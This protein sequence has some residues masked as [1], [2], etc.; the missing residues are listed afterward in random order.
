MTDL[1]IDTPEKERAVRDWIQANTDY[2]NSEAVK[3]MEQRILNCPNR[4]C[5]EAF[6]ELLKYAE[7]QETDDADAV[8]EA[9]ADASMRWKREGGN[10]PRC[11]RTM[12]DHEASDAHQALMRAKSNLI[13]VLGLDP[14]VATHLVFKP[15]AS[16]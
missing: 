16:N 11:V 1:R 15:E 7:T 5:A 13:K 12:A 8:L 14:N 2:D 10:C 3:T 6:R 9:G 4:T